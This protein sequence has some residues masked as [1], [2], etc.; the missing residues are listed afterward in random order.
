MYVHRSWPS[1]TGFE[2]SRICGFGRPRSRALSLSRCPGSR[3]HVCVYMCGCVCAALACL[4][5]CTHIP[6]ITSLRRSP[7][8]YGQR[9]QAS[10]HT[11]SLGS[12]H[13]REGQRSQSSLRPRCCLRCRTACLGSNSRRKVREA[14]HCSLLDTAGQPAVSGHSVGHSVINTTM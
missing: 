6:N 5:V 14:C 8:G 9:T 3:W 13:F 4:R 2:H 1:L 12:R 10:A 7:G 11:P